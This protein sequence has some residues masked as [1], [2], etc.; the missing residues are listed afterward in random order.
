VNKQPDSDNEMPDC[1][2]A[3]AELTPAR[4]ALA[5][6]FVCQA[7]LARDQRD[8]ALRTL[9]AR[10]AHQI[11][12]PLAAVRAACSGL[13]EEI[14]NPDQRETLDLTQHEIERMLGFVQATVQAVVPPRNEQPQSIDI[15]AEVRDVLS[16]V[17]SGQPG[18]ARIELAPSSRPLTCSM[19]RD[20]LRVAIYSVLDHLA[21]S[22]GI[23]T[24][25]VILVRQT[26]RV[27]VHFAIT[28]NAVAYEGVPADTSAADVW[29]Q[30]IG[31][32]IAERFAR[33]QGGRLMRTDN[34]DTGQTLTLDL[35]C[36]DA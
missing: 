30:P 29:G 31:L 21:V 3:P 16:L 12:N 34:G 33:D 4:A 28:G 14:D 36:S 8:A 26:G 15:S 7:Q 23:E 9:A 22:P 10:L 17:R 24:V 19:P 32:L 25:G 20:A 27:L 11:R 18:R 13:K 6:A 5:N 2:D 1:A 35:P